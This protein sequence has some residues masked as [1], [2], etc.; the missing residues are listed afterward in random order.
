MDFCFAGRGHQGQYSP[1]PPHPSKLHPLRWGGGGCWVIDTS[2]ASDVSLWCA[3]EVSVDSPLLP[4]NRL[5]PS[6][7]RPQC[8][9][10]AGWRGGGRRGVSSFRSPA[11]HWRLSRQCTTRRSHTLDVSS[12]SGTCSCVTVSAWLTPK[13]L[14]EAGCFQAKSKCVFISHGLWE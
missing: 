5:H 10:C 9:T 8:C 11:L 6:P 3:A 7:M 13:K 12:L 4:L 2:D 1:L 14:L